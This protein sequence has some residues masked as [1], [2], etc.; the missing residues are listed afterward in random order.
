MVMFGLFDDEDDVFTGS[1]KSKF[2]DIVFNANNDVVRHQLSNFIERVAAM[3]MMLCESMS[4]GEME[5]RIRNTVL[6]ASPEFEDT[7]R[8]IYIELMGNIVTQS[9]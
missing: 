1:P 5:K 9:E 7:V 4:D 2:M 3:E 6:T 8:S